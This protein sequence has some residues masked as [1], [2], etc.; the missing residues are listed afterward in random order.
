MSTG[1]RDRQGRR[2]RGLLD[3]L[4]T[5]SNAQSIRARAPKRPS[6]KLVHLS[7][8]AMLGE[9]VRET[10]KAGGLSQQELADMAGVGRRFVSELENGKSTLEFGRVLIVCAASGID[11]H[12]RT[13]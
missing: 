11:V 12:A 8:P 10:R 2:K 6:S 5:A 4:A 1:K 13:R 3:D 9:M 7:S